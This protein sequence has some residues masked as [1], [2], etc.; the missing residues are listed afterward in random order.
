[1]ENLNVPAEVTWIEPMPDP[2]DVA[3]E[4]DTIRLAFV[5]ALQHLPA[6]AARRADPLRGAALAGVRGRGAARHLRRV[7]QQRAPARTRD[8][9]HG[10]RRTRSTPRRR[11]RAAR[12]LRR[13][14]RGVRHR[15]ADGAHPR[16]R[17]AV[18]AA[19]R[20]VARRARRHPHL[21]VRARHRLPGLAR[22]PGRAPRT[23]RRRSVSTS[24]ARRAA[25]SRGRSRCSRLKDGRIVEL[26]FFLD[27]DGSSRSSDCRCG[28][29][30]AAADLG[31]P[32]WTW[33]TR[34]RRSSSRA[35]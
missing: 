32:W 2:A 27:T 1:M 16:G 18:D 33:P 31:Y 12:A 21:V 19:V 24:R 10:E 11:P 29:P 26:T 35:K 9:R 7:G 8:A 17:D 6:T 5:A 30:T 3:V 22:R 34:K 25:T 28:S 15:R 13:R 4:R 14:L 23:A 20:P